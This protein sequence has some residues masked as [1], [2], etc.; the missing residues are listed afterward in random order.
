M[1]VD[2]W[3]DNP[4]DWMFGLRA[5]DR[6]KKATRLAPTFTGPKAD[7]FYCTKTQTKVP[8]HGGL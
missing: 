2:V 7:W 6:F 4:Q 1:T 3:T 5:Y 8:T